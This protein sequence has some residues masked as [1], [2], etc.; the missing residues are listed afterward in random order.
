MCA[1]VWLGGVVREP[2]D[3]GV[4]WDMDGT[5]VAS[6]TVVPDAFIEV[7]ARLGSTPPDRDG[8]VAL[9]DTGTPR[10]MLGHMLDRRGTEEDTELYHEVLRRRTAEV[11]VHGG[12]EAV[13]SEVRRRGVPQAVFTGNTRQA[14]E[15]LLEG[16]G[17]RSHFDVVVGGDEVAGPKPAPDGVLEA[18][19]R[20]GLTARSCLYVGDSPLDVGAAEAAGA[21][22]VHAG[23]GHLYDDALGHATAFAPADVLTFLDRLVG[24]GRQAG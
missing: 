6:A 16:T 24:S 2:T 18:A 5:L 14:A 23:W 21:V 13:L 22:P 12:I 1:A 7:V 9:Y 3:V 17:L 11:R 20:L 19:Q 4:I 8:V 15:I 10:T